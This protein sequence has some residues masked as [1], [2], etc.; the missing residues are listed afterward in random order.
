LRLS[1]ITSICVKK[2]LHFFEAKSIFRLSD[3]SSFFRHHDSKW[4]LLYSMTG[5]FFLMFK[6]IYKLCRKAYLVHNREIL[7]RNQIIWKFILLRFEVSYF[8]ND[9]FFNST[10]E[11]NMKM[12]F[13][14]KW[15]IRKTI[16]LCWIG[17]ISAFFLSLPTIL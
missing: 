13:E 7:K 12:I 1:E 5:I 3:H 2:G 6:T 11:L 9:S 15:N 17:L 8:L 16:S 10:E 14:M 4:T